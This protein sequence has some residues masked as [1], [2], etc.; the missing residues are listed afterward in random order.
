MRLKYLN[1]LD[2]SKIFPKDR[3]ILK[4]YDRKFFDESSTG[5]DHYEPKIASYKD[6]L[7]TYVNMIEKRQSPSIQ[8]DF[9]DLL[10]EICGIQKKSYPF[11]RDMHLDVVSKPIQF[12]APVSKQDTTLE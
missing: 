1:L 10:H 6:L 11:N 2:K 8:D 7:S 12:V 3:D 4:H 5:P 9:S